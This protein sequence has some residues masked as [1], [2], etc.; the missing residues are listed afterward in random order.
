MEDA[1]QPLSKK[2]ATLSCIHDDGE[3]LNA[4]NLFD[5]PVGF[6]ESG[7]LEK[8]RKFKSTKTYTKK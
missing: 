4:S 8:I 6:A 7:K 5:V 3:S 2:I 1:L